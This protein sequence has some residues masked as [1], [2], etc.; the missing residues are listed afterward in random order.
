MNIEKNEI[1]CMKE[2]CNSVY[3]VA[4][5]DLKKNNYVDFYDAKKFIETGTENLYAEVLGFTDNDIRLLLEKNN[6]DLRKIEIEFFERKIKSFEKFIN[7]DNG[8]Y[9][10]ILLMCEKGKSTQEIQNEFNVS[11]EKISNLKYRQREINQYKTKINEL[12][13]F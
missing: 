1:D 2:L 3:K 11:Y 4:L 9:K 13:N 12:M 7:K 5:A 10:K 6:I 8:F